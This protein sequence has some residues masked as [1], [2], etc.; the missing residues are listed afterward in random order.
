[1][2]RKHFGPRFEA[3]W[4]EGKLWTAEQLE[5]CSDGGSAIFCVALAGGAWCVLM[6]PEMINSCR[7]KIAQ[8][9]STKI[10]RS[11]DDRVMIAGKWKMS[12]RRRR[13]FAESDT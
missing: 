3:L 5:P 7:A 6:R 2:I 12:D 1:V 11:S 13:L 9:R 4:V 10:P 8:H